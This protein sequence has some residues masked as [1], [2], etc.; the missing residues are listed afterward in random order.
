MLRLS[1]AS[2]FYS[3]MPAAHLASRA[4]QMPDFNIFP[5][6]DE[7]WAARC[8]TI[9]PKQYA[10][11]RNFL[12]GAVTRL[13][14]YLSHGMTSLKAVAQAVAQKHPLAWDDK[15]V[16]ELAWRAF[17]LQVQ[18]EAGNA[19]LKDMRNSVL[20]G[21]RYQRDLPVDIREGKTGVRAIDRAVAELY[22]TGY[23]H[24]HARMWVASYVVHVRKVHW[25]AG[26][27]W[28][29]RHLLDGEI[30]SNH[31]SWQWVA[32]TFSTKPY[33]FNNENVSR[34]APDWGQTG[35]FI[36]RSYPELEDHASHGRD[37]GPE[38]HAPQNGI[39][40][41]ELYR[42]TEIRT[43]AAEAGLELWVEQLPEGPIGRL[44]HPTAL[45]TDPSPDRQTALGWIHLPAHLSWP[46]SARRWS[47][48]LR[49]MAL[50]TNRVLITRAVS[51]PLFD[52]LAGALPAG[53]RLPICR[54]PGY[55]APISSLARAGVKTYS[56]QDLFP[57][58][59]QR[60]PS[61]SRYYQSIQR[62]APDFSSL[63][64]LP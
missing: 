50:L 13:S 47:F 36:D 10:R 58:P 9:D 19:I 26:A 23:L 11:S 64:H 62:Q 54:I 48:V 12:N 55:E 35:S 56:D 59:G 21:V 1:L 3:A 29:W 24:N 17:F 28:M 20:P 60:C 6:D 15:L 7:A 4:F 32:G 8:R 53:A 52:S 46:W 63:L 57:E 49:R 5:V 37:A 30:A 51:G 18:K 42:E 41:P 40:E 61:F 16:A 39:P 25:R 33:L 38:A 31:L 27:D 45:H 43:Q 14:P 34:Y 44:I 2:I 22:Q